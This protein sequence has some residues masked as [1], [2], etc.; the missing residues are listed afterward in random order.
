VGNPNLAL[1][2]QVMARITLLKGRSESM[3]DEVALREMARKAMR[4]GKFPDR[5]PGRMWGGPGS[6]DI[7]AVCNA[8]VTR[9]E[10][11]FDL[12]FAG[13]RGQQVS[14]AFHVPCFAAWELERDAS[15]L[16]NLPPG[17]GPIAQLIELRA[18]SEHGTMRRH[19]RD[20]PDAGAAE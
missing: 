9:E 17:K 15:Q 4:A 19:E 16:S 14:Y 5:Q 1:C 18:N 13:D 12:E 7:C 10:M 2:R 20:N 6:G 3:T 11:G 8:A